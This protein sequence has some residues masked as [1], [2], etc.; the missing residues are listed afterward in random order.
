MM[1]L[2]SNVADRKGYY[3]VRYRLPG[4]SV[5]NKLE[6]LYHVGSSYLPCSIIGSDEIYPEGEYEFLYRLDL[7]SMA[8]KL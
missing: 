8:D 5:D 7:E 4:H 3:L 6:L 2:D 1:Q